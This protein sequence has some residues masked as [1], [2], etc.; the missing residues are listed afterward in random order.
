MARKGHHSERSG[1]RVPEAVAPE[2]EHQ[3]KNVPPRWRRQMHRLLELRERV[4]A[5]QRCQAQAAL[6]ER[7]G[8]SMHM[9]DAGTDSYDRDLALGLL[10]HEQDALYEIEAALD[11][12]RNGTYGLCEL[13]GRPIPPARLE[14]IPWT[15]F[16]ADAERELE[17]TGES[18]PAHLGSRQSA[19]AEQ[20]RRPRPR[21]KELL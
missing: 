3:G 15:R 16:A 11:R 7:P 13:T 14:A 12:L 1:A 8:F 9:A 21:S 4:L 19:R 6:E 2:P 18:R 20:Q 5:A 17:T 10:S